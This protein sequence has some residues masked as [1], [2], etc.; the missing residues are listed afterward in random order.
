MHA[1]HGIHLPHPCSSLVILEAPDTFYYIQSA[2]LANIIGLTR[3]C[4]NQFT[5]QR[6]KT[7]RIQATDVENLYITACRHETS[8][9]TQ[10]SLIQHI[11]HPTAPTHGTTIGP[12]VP[13]MDAN[14]TE[15]N[16]AGPNGRQY[17][18]LTGQARRM[19]NSGP[20]ERRGRS[21]HERRR[22]YGRQSIVMPWCLIARGDLSDCELAR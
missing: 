8:V 15:P 13:S 1:W 17:G 4:D 9:L 10:G 21:R 7:P 16:P 19:P 22:F 18:R 2:D 6:V 11:P 14:T 20:S 12:A 3:G 5:L